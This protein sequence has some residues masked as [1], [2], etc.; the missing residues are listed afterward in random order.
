MVRV[1]LHVKD[2]SKKF[3]AETISVSCYIVNCVYL[4]SV[5]NQ[6][7]FELW[8]CKK[9]NPKRIQ[10]F[11]SKCFILKDLENLDKFHYRSDKG[12]YLPR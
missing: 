2:I 3:W 4:C 9:S 11:G 1:L 8:K 7:P 12:T 6:I 10:L 5:T